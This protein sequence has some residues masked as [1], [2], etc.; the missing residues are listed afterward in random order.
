MIFFEVKLNICQDLGSD[1]I[2]TFKFGTLWKMGP[3]ME[4][5]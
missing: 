3:V 5:T 1:R 4:C 2:I